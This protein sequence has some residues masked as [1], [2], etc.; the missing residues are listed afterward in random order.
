MWKS[1]QK[2]STQVQRQIFQHRTGPPEPK[3]WRTSHSG[4]Q[5]NHLA[6]Y[7]SHR[8]ARFSLVF[9]SP[10]RCHGPKFLSTGITGL[11]HRFKPVLVAL[12]MFLS[13]YITRSTNQS[14]S[15]IK[16]LSLMQMRKSV[17][18]WVLLR[19]KETHSPIGS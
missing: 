12:R 19:T 7:G 5:T 11:D 17:A 16:N 15:Q 1:I 6:S 10:V 3:P 14:I 13:Y 2:N 4:R 9:L 18:G 8:R